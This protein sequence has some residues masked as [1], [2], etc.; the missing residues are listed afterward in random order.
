MPTN[1]PSPQNVR[2]VLLEA[3][4][5]HQAGD[6]D[7]AAGLYREAL[8]LDPQQPDG[9]R[10]LGTLLLQTGRFAEAEHTLRYALSLAPADAETYSNLGAV[11]IHTGR[12]A[13]A[14]PALRTATSLRPGFA[15]AL[16]NLGE[17]LRQTGDAAGARAALVQALAVNAD[18]V[19]ALFNLGVLKTAERDYAGAAQC[20]ERALTL[21]PGHVAAR[22]QLVNAYVTA[23][24]Y[25]KAEQH[26]R[27]L[28]D[29]DP[30]DHEVRVALASIFIAARQYD[31]A[32]R[33]VRHV[34]DRDPDHPRAKVCLGQILR[35]TGRQDEALAVFREVAAA[36]PEEPRASAGIVEIL[37][38]RGDLDAALALAEE[39]VSR[40]PDN[41]F[42]RL[43]LGT[44]L[45]KLG[46]P[47]DACDVYRAGL[48]LLPDQPGLHFNL[49]IQLLLLGRFE[50][51]WKEYGW[52]TKLAT[53]GIRETG[54]TSWR[55]EPLEGKTLL[56]EAEQGL[57]DMIQFVRL[58]PLAAARGADVLL[59]CQPELMRLFESAAGIRRIVQKPETGQA[60]VQADAYLPLLSLP[61][62]L[63]IRLENVPADVPYLAPPANLAAAW[64]ERLA[65]DAG[66]RVGI[67]WSGNPQHIDDANRSCPLD[68]FA[69][70]LAVPGATFYSLQKGG[71]AALLAAGLDGKVRDHSDEWT[72]FA[73]T[74][75]FMQSL[76][77]VIAVDTAAVHLAGAMGLPAW[78][79][80]PFA[81]DWRWLLDRKDSP[82]YP[83]LRL[84][85][86][87][88]P[89]DWPSVIGQA[90]SMLSEEIRSRAGRPR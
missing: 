87:P 27:S 49:G 57:G 37:L 55:G 54:R 56:I 66:F 60:Q 5:L 67:A 76:D 63:D 68:R 12:L 17:A 9:N 3:L 35:Q 71:A 30:D 25:L 43:D 70:L 18:H 82:W 90:A 41:G 61:E 81:P 1:A 64:K 65:G 85:R 40:H 59:E 4:R 86:P 88:Q 6:F 78:A 52:R 20:L 74:A 7:A 29:R 44:V 31:E 89:R 50:E 75:A 11:L 47:E 24:E 10:L 33:Q 69:P 58:A 8:A 32:M 77:L 46:R 83:T 48:A 79:L 14:I 21:F 22:R 16:S 38:R 26:C 13:E 51:G 15:D 53:W 39:I 73:D 19:N 36:H 23:S 72:D 84:V 80:L 42:M 2:A 62:V 34:L 28:L 45:E